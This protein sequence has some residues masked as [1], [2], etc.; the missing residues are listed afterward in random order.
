M[1]SLKG[2]KPKGQSKLV[3]LRD[4]G[5]IIPDFWVSGG[6]LS[7]FYQKLYQSG[8]FDDMA[9]KLLDDPHSLVQGYRNTLDRF[10]SDY[11]EDSS[12]EA[13]VIK[14]SKSKKII[15][16]RHGFVQ[17]RKNIARAVKSKSA[18]QLFGAEGQIKFLVRSADPVVRIA[19]SL[20][21]G[22]P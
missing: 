12:F 5:G 3:A 4:A 18:R 19:E 9:L 1:L 14:T 20:P 2:N 8:S 16:D 13:L 10:V 6:R 21:G 22:R 15:F 17:D 11:S 7:D